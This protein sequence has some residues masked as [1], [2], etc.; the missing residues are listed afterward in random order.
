MSDAGLQSRYTILHRLAAGGMA[1][2]YVG[3]MA[4]T[5]GVRKQVVIKRIL[6][7]LA[8]DRAFVRMFLDEARVAATLQHPNIVQT[9]DV[10]E[11]TDGYFIAME[12]LVGADVRS[13]G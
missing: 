5:S 9:H 12:Y 3:E 10:V 13:V 6:P 1:E 11:G 8:K 7:D 2:V 4:A